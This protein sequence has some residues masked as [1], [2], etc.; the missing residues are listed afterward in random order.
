MSARFAPRPFCSA[1][2]SVLPRHMQISSDD[3]VASVSQTGAVKAKKSGTVIITAQ[4]MDDSG[5]EAACEVTVVMGTT[6]AK[7]IYKKYYNDNLK[8]KSKYPSGSYKLY[9]INQ[10]GIPEMFLKYEGGVR[11]AYNIYALAGN[12]VKLVSIQYGVNEINYN[13]GKK[14]ICIR[15]SSSAFKSYYTVYQ[16]KGIKLRKIV[17]YTYK[18]KDSSGKTVYYKDKKKISSSKFK[19]IMKQIDKWPSL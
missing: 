12:K 6:A 7:E 1:K 13:A 10:D 9:D 5:I 19:T 18:S 14:Q 8:N 16:L 3:S 2:L 11:T 17:K 15:S 4:A